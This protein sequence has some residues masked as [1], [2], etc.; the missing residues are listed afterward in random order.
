MININGTVTATSVQ[1]DELCDMQLY[2]VISNGEG[3]QAE[4]NQK[5]IKMKY[6]VLDNPDWLVLM[7]EQYSS[8]PHKDVAEIMEWLLEEMK[9]VLV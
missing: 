1:I 8:Q 6:V 5:P 3:T 9:R 4:W 2:A 7:Y